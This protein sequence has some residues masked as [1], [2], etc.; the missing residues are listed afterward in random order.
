MYR[1]LYFAAIII[2][3]PII[4][5]CIIIAGICYLIK[6]P[7]RKKEYANS[8]YYK[9]FKLPFKECV[10][11]SPEYRFYNSIK[12]RN[13]PVKYTRQE[14][15]GLEYFVYGDT[16]YLFPDFDDMNFDEEEA[17]W[18]VDYDGVR[19]PFEDAYQ[20]IISRVD[21]IT[22]DYQV[23]LLLERK[24]LPMD[25]SG[26]NIPDSVFVTWSLESVFDNEDSRLKLRVPEN[27][28]E[29]YEMMRLTPDLCGEYFITDN[30]SISWN[31]YDGA[32]IEISIGLS[33]C[34]IAV[35][36]NGFGKI[37]NEM[38]HWHPSLYE[39]YG[40]VCELGKLESVL[41]IRTSLIGSAVIYMG[42]R[43]NCPYKKYKKQFFGKIHY[44]EVKPN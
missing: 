27:T 44:M 26:V 9:D 13:L 37:K 4:M 5:C 7:K 34:C 15:N 38:T 29:L 16:L 23:K 30:E 18:E 32:Q 3:F 19:K 17:I 8:Q 31:V 12:K 35:I 28:R 40:E 41:V 39:I 21:D 14:S 25:I 42:D 36:R 43:E 2:F 33:D 11:Y 10:L 20:S 22:G 1:I 6:L 24:K